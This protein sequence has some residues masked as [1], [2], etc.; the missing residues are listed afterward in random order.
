[1]VSIRVESAAV[2]PC[3]GPHP[4]GIHHR[5]DRHVQLFQQRTK[6]ADRQVPG[7][8]ECDLVAR[9]LVTMLRTDDEY[10]NPGSVALE[11][12]AEADTEGDQRDDNRRPCHS[13][14]LG[15]QR[16]D[17]Q[18]RASQ[19]REFRQPYQSGIRRCV[20]QVICGLG[21]GLLHRGR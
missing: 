3:A 11:P 9:P 5:H 16:V 20:C 8:S 6:V 4:H 7:E 18:H 15:Q 14:G 12:T 10:P 2:E 19:R 13:S 17:P 1:M 21:R